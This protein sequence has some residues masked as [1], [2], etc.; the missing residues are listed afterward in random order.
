MIVI[1]LHDEVADTWSNPVVANNEAS[2]RRDFESACAD[3][4]SL[5]GQHPTDF[6]LFAIADWQ[7]SSEP[8]A[9]PHFK[10]FD[11]FKFLASG[12]PHEQK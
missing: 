12:V 3:S 4:R 6:K 2:A 7:P 11:S 10:A 8:G 9:L 5:I 1:T